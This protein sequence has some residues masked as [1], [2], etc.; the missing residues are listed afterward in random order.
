[1][2]EHQGVA[3]Q[4]LRPEK[5]TGPSISVTTEPPAAG[6]TPHTHGAGAESP[7]PKSR[8][9]QDGSFAIEDFPVPTGREEEW[10]FTPLRRLRG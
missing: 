7:R 6:A 5:G 10:R 9:H 8:L 2:T 4:V 1:M 3:A